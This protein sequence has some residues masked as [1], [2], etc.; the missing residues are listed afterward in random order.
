MGC[1]W[2][3]QFCPS[4]DIVVKADD[5]MVVDVYLLFRHIA[6]LRS[7]GK[8][9]TNTILCDVWYHRSVERASGKWKVSE[10]EYADK[11]YPPY[12]PGLGLVMT[13][14]IVPKMYNESLYEPYFW[15]DDVY[16]TGLLAQTINVTFEQLAATVHFGSSQM[17]RTQT[18]FDNEYQ[19]MFYHIQEK[20]VSAMMWE[21][22]HKRELNR[23]T[24]Q[25]ASPAA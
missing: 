21:N 24:Y 9:L 7:Q 20:P 2:T 15:V 6:S 25:S 19:W 11:F 10:E 17:V 4:A 22:I 18:N 16:F 5:D 8:V 23:Q 13:A 14:D 3:T 1:K 12:C